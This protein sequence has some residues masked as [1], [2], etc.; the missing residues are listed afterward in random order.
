MFKI[1]RQSYKDEFKREVVEPW[2]QSVDRASEVR[3]KYLLA[4]RAVSQIGWQ[5]RLSTVGRTLPVKFNHLNGRYASQN[6]HS[7][8]L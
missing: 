2:R 7:N 8:F 6:N 1:P 3:S 4:H 5:P